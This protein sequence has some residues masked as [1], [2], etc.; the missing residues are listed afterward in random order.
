MTDEHNSEVMRGIRQAD[1]CYHWCSNQP[2][3]C[4]ISREDQTHQWHKKLSHVSL[5]TLGKALKHDAIMG[6]LVLDVKIWKFSTWK[7][8]LDYP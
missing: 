7:T 1:N 4:K 3:S 2:D 5:V 8:Y 6:L